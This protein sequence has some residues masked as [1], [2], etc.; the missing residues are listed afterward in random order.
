MPISNNDRM[1]IM[2]QIHSLGTFNA[3]EKYN[4][5]FDELSM[6]RNSLDLNVNMGLLSNRDFE[7][8]VE[9]IVVFEGLRDDL[10]WWARTK[11]RMQLV[12]QYT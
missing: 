5:C 10:G 11:R 8:V 6:H 7:L 9:Y 2:A 3:E 4:A 12:K 1:N